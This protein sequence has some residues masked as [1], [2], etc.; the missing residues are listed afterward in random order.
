VVCSAVFCDSLKEVERNSNFPDGDSMAHFASKS[1]WQN[2]FVLCI[3]NETSNLFVDTIIQELRK[4][5]STPF[6]GRY[7]EVGSVQ[8]WSGFLAFFITS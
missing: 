7:F 2:H 5:F 4:I 8:I 6:A 3:E 1:S